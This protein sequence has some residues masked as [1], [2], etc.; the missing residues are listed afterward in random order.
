MI[1][2]QKVVRAVL[3]IIVMG[4]V[5]ALLYWLIGALGLPHPF[6]RV[7]YGVLLVAAVFTLIGIILDFAGMPIIKWKDE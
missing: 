4:A 3:L 7:A 5:Y 2:I 1:S 6:G